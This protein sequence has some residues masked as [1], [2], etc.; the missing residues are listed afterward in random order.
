MLASVG[1]IGLENSTRTLT[2]P[3]AATK[4][5][6]PVEPRRFLMSQ[7]KVDAPKAQAEPIPQDDVSKLISEAMKRSERLV[8]DALKLSK[9][10]VGSNAEDLRIRLR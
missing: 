8:Q 9:S 7:P 5:P 2:T 3:N 4:I 10:L 6:H 1:Y